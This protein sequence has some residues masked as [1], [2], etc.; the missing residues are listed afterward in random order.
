MAV[1]ADEVYPVFSLHPGSGQ[2][3]SGNKHFEDT[4]ATLV[5]LSDNIVSET[6]Q[7]DENISI[8]LDAE[9][10]LVSIAI[11]HAST[12]ANMREVAFQ[13]VTAED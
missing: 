11:E 10:K 1:E 9:G 2:A 6:R 5:E 3:P 4:D 7:I 12:Q 13:R 8:D